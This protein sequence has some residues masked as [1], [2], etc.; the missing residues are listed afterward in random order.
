M[1]EKKLQMECKQK[2]IN[3]TTFQVNN[4]T[5]LKEKRKKETSRLRTCFSS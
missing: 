1:E 5:T 3:Q 4:I 2:Q